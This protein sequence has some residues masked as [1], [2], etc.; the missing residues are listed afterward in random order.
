L[1]LIELKEVVFLL[2]SLGRIRLL[3]QRN[4]GGLILFR[5]GCLAYRSCFERLAL[6]LLQT[7]LLAF[8]RLIYFLASFSYNFL[9]V[10]PY[11][12]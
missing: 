10:P 1:R 12:V 9:F 7:R 5:T 11:S 4:L 6:F 8:F 3:L 2:G